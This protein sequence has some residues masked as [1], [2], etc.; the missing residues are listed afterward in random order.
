ME[1]GVDMAA[2]LTMADALKYVTIQQRED[3]EIVGQMALSRKKSTTNKPIAA[4][5]KR[6]A[7]DAC[8]DSGETARNCKRSKSS[9]AR[10]KQNLSLLAKYKEQ[11]GTC[12]VL[13]CRVY[14][15]PVYK[16]RTISRKLYSWVAYQK[17]EIYKYDQHPATSDLDE[18]EYKSLMDLGL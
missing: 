17:S 15:D 4:S 10:W 12:A 3:T 6:N 8:L 1:M 5:A 14:K 11:Y 9:T 13:Y 2:G 7:V 16:D 18:E